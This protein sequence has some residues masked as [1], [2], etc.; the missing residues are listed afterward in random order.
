MIAFLMSPSPDWFDDSDGWDIGPLYWA[1]VEEGLLSWFPDRQSRTVAIR[2]D[3]KHPAM[4]NLRRR[5]AIDFLAC[6]AD[7]QDDDRVRRTR[8]GRWELLPT[9]DESLARTLMDASVT[10]TGRST[11][12]AFDLS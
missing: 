4:V 6:P 9:D 5:G 2:M 12:Y 7:L 10:P 3:R 8:T 1:I 11:D